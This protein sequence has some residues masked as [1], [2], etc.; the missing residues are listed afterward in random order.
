MD[1][2]N[3]ASSLPVMVPFIIA[4][5]GAAENRV[6]RARKKGAERLNLAVDFIA[7]SAFSPSLS[8]S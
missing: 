5:D 4:F 1:V 2:A 8:M 3:T 7:S 6:R